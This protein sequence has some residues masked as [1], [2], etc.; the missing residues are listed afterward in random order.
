MRL[1]FAPVSTRLLARCATLL[2]FDQELL[3]T[4]SELDAEGLAVLLERS[5]AVPVPDRTGAYHLRGDIR[6]STLDHLRADQPLE[7]LNLHLKA[8]AHFLGQIG[9]DEVTSQQ[10]DAEVCCIYHLEELF[11]LLRQRQDWHTILQLCADLRSAHPQ[12]PQLVHRLRLYEGY[13]LVH[14]EEYDRGEPILTALLDQPDLE[15]AQRLLVL[16]GLANAHWF[17][18]K[19]D[20]A[21]AIYEQIFT[22]ARAAGDQL[23]QGL[24]LI[25]MSNAYNELRQ[26]ERAFDL[27][28]QSLEVFRALGDVVRTAHALYRIGNN[29]MYLG[30]WDLAREHLALAITHFET[31]QME[32]NLALVYW[33]EGYLFHMLG[34]DIRSEAAYLRALPLAKSSSHRQTYLAQE[35][36]RNLGFLYETQGRL[37]EALSLYEQAMQAA[38]QLRGAHWLSLSHYRRGNVFQRQGRTDDAFAAYREAI[39]GIES[40]RSSTEVEEIKIGLLGTTQQVYE[41][42]VLLCLDQDRPAE[43][44]DYV[45]RA[46]SRAFLDTL[47]KKSPELY[48]AVAQPV[49]TLQEVQ[50]RLPEG[51]LL[52][53]Y[54]TIGV[55]PTGEHLLHQ[56]PKENTRLREHLILSPTILI[57]AVTHDRLEIHRA[58]LDPNVL[59]PRPD[60]PSS[61][62]RL[63][64]ERMLVSLEERLIGPVRHLLHGCDLLYLIPHGP[65][66][67]VP[68]MA[69]RSAAGTHLLAA[70][71]PA[72]AL[73]PSATVLLRNCLSRPKRQAEGLL[74]LGY[75]DADERA[76][77]YAEAEAQH[78]ARLLAGQAWVGPEPKSRRLLDQGQTA[79]RL[80][81]A[82]HAIYD[83]RDPLESHLR[84]GVGDQLSARAL[85]AGLEFDADLVTLSACTSGLTHVVPGDE[86][87]GLQ[88]AF[89]YAGAA[90]VVC[91][92]WETFD[93]VAL[94]VMD[95]F[96]TD[97]RQGLPTAAALRDAQVAVRSMTGRDV[98]AIIARWRAEDPEFIAELGVL[99]DIPPDQYDALLY[100]DPFY[101]APFMLIGRPD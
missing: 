15:F 101:W 20:R 6:D 34:D 37:N 8:F 54:F 3:T 49:A 85:I 81:I 23:Y 80:H 52:L 90:A 13:T 70:D 25:N 27:S 19:Y 61:G 50:A 32:A 24:A 86:L 59:R 63:L 82:G 60:N 53:E 69:L 22:L 97:L 47:I 95:H 7:L 91:T 33:S 78:V 96:Y 36:E 17:Q 51:A 67:S 10:M 11:S 39:E 35:V 57:F 71:G 56:L 87:L 66:H 12:N 83:L 44:F 41:S 21:L 62:R 2:W 42:M 4:L 31:L 14:V 68:F 73:A 98:A 9:P 5:L 58:T 76:L 38:T 26:F 18:T 100:A 29:A 43:A 84:L 92:L 79:S 45:E 94:L 48:A 1:D 16:S 93:F 40:L 30:R 88:R 72:V 99:P 55:L 75:N 28:L 89:L 74:A 64:H 46:R 77:R 65:L